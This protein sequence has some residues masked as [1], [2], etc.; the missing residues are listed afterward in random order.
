MT[1]GRRWLVI[2]H[3]GTRRSAAR[4]AACGVAA[5]LAGCGG[6][7]AAG[8]PARAPAPPAALPG[9][10]S[11]GAAGGGT[12]AVVVMGGSRARHDNFWQLFMRSSA[13][14]PWRLATPPGVADN[15]GLAVTAAGGRTLVTGFRPSQDLRFSPVAVSA[16]DGAHWAQ[17]APVYPGLAGGPAALAAGPGGALL[18]LTSGGEVQRS[19]RLGSAWRQLSSTAALARTAAG[20]ACELTRLTAVAF[21]QAGAAMLGGACAKP[22]A[23]GIFKQAGRGWRAAVL[24]LPAA[25]ARS[26]AEVVSLQ[27]TGA[28]TTALIRAGSGSGTALLAAWSGAAGRAG[29]R[30]QWQLSRPAQTGQAAIRSVSLGTGG[31]AGVVLSGGQD[32]WI[33]A[34]GSGWQQLPAL[35]PH[36]QALA[37]GPAGQ[38]DAVAASGGT[39]TAWRRAPGGRGWVQAQRIAV[40]I[41]YG[42]SG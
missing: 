14:A 19:A 31:S 20:R 12:G 17:A 32:A 34:P 27:T 11:F 23:A 29:T 15:G 13:T 21:T 30:P 36:A 41:P 22:G 5:L 35:P 1:G 4:L 9:A 10:S 42:S 24:P 39:M 8:G 26:R 16:D 33:A 7:A 2:S 6:A 3:P 37:A 40:Q 18:A 25:L 28:L 38:V